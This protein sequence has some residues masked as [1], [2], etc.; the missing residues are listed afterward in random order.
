[1]S[2]ECYNYTTQKDAHTALMNS[3]YN[4]LYVCGVAH[5]MTKD[6]PDEIALRMWHGGLCPGHGTKAYLRDTDPENVDRYGGLPDG[7]FC[8]EDDC[9]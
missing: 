6:E 9:E 7:D 3:G 4:F 2:H 5:M 1:M 8:T